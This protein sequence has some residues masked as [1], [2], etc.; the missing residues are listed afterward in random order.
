MMTVDC[1]Q[2][3]T[4]GGWFESLSKLSMIPTGHPKCKLPCPK[5]TV[6][7]PPEVAM[8]PLTL[9]KMIHRH[10]RC[11]PTAESRLQ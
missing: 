9:T 1:H 3:V 2:T 10:Y 6:Q 5:R 4:Q 7:S 11:T 8:L